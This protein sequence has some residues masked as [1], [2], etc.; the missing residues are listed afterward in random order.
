VSTSDI[1]LGSSGTRECIYRAQ[2]LGRT[3][4][5]QEEDS[6][7]DIYFNGLPNNQ[8]GGTEQGDGGGLVMELDEIRRLNSCGYVARRQNLGQTYMVNGRLEN[9]KLKQLN[10]ERN[11]YRIKYIA[12]QTMRE[13]AVE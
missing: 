6:P 3:Q 13:N 4:Y 10:R 12:N 8:I 9:K 7:A 5:R 11:W 1:S 2:V